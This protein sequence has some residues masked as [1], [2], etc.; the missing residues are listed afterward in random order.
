MDDDT[1]MIFEVIAKGMTHLSSRID[2]TVDEIGEEQC[3]YCG[4]PAS[5]SFY[6]LRRRERT[7]LCGACLPPNGHS[8]TSRST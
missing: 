5:V 3:A 6:H 4:L 8:A 2:I 1:E 7:L